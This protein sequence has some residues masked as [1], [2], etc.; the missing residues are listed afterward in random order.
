MRHLLS[1]MPYENKDDESIGVSD[2][3]IVHSAARYYDDRVDQST[4]DDV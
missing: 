4:L 2:S 1:L 3:L